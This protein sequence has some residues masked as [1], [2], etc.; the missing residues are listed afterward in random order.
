LFSSAI[1][2]L[3]GGLDGVRYELGQHLPDQRTQRS[4]RRDTLGWP[5]PKMALAASWVMFSRISATTIATDRNR[6]IPAGWPPG[7]STSPQRWQI[8]VAS[9]VGAHGSIL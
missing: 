5:T 2:S 1:G 8:R 7:R 9:S 6:P 4:R 3:T